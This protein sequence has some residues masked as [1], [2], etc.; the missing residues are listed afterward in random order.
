[1]NVGIIGLGFVGSAIMKSL[2][3]KK[4]TVKGYDINKES[5][6][7]LNTINSDILF[8]CLPTIYC[9]EKKE[10]DKSSIISVCN[11]LLNN[12][13]N[14]IVVV[15]STV[16]PTT[17]QELANKYPMLKFVNNPEFLTAKTAFDDFHNQK[18]IVL[19]KTHRISNVD[20]DLLQTFYKLYYPE[21][22]IS[23]CSSTES[24]AMKIFVNS[25]YA[26]KI[27]MFNEFYALC[28]NIGCDYETVKNLM[29]KNGWINPMHT[30]VP[31]TDGQL[32]YGGYCFPKDTNA[33][34]EFMKCRQSPSKVLEATVLERN[35]MREDNL[36]VNKNNVIIKY[37]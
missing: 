21:A 17:T 1:M 2:I 7:F 11:D 30:N 31:G 34:L 35:Q 28:S 15:K 20:I 32:S 13:Y 37:K 8:L 23:I 16:E 6:S 27:Q 12:N 14:G 5:D 29:L 4:C 19:G 9:E 33:L 3:L 25:F 18:H 10:Y 36:N 26:V 24:E 22:E